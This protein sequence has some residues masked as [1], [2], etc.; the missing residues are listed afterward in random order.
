MLLS[1]IGLAPPDAITAFEVE[2][3]PRERAGVSVLH[4]PKVLLFEQGQ[5]F[6]LSGG[7]FEV[8]FHNIYIVKPHKRAM[9]FL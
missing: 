1:V 5:V 2:F 8:L 4:G 6:S 9:N 3:L 7:F